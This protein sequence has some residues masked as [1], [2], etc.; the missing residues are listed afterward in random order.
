MRSPS[1][2][3]VNCAR[4]LALSRPLSLALSRPLSRSPALCSLT[5]VHTFTRTFTHVRRTACAKSAKPGTRARDAMF[6]IASGRRSI[7]SR[8]NRLRTRA[9]RS[10]K[11]ISL[12]AHTSSRSGGRRSRLHSQNCR[13]GRLVLAEQC[14]VLT[15]STTAV[16][17]S[18]CSSRVMTRAT[19]NLRTGMMCHGSR[20]AATRRRQLSPRLRYHEIPLPAE[21]KLC[22]FARSLSLSLNPKV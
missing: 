18:L 9:S 10:S 17:T 20:E 1:P 14:Q 6:R 3:S 7:S 11:R 12:I 5:H 13:R 2:P 16:R 8:R 19:K 15:V 4:S 22:S 21:R